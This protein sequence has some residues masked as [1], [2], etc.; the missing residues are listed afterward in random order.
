M[1][2]YNSE[3][4]TIRFSFILFAVLLLG[5]CTSRDAWSTYSVEGD[6]MLL[7]YSFE[8]PS[9]WT[10]DEGNNYIGFVSDSDLLKDVP[11]KLKPGQI[12]VGLSMNINMSPEE[13]VLT[14]TDG[15]H[16]FIDF[17]DPVFLTLD[18]RPAVY[19]EGVNFETKDETLVI[20]V[21]L[22]QNM[23]GLLEARMAEGELEVWRETLMKMVRSLK[24]K[25]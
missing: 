11:S 21:D 15:L 7:P 24:I 18:G 22:G 8:Y 19:Q 17:S 9:S 5:A 3:M 13:M 20:A 14:R 1:F 25:L 16:G 6:K 23:R 4:K 10:M 2:V 12:I